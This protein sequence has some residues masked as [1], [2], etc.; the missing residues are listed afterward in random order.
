MIVEIKFFYENTQEDY[1][2][3][4]KLWH[5]NFKRFIFLQTLMTIKEQSKCISNCID[6]NKNILAIRWEHIDII[7]KNSIVR[8]IVLGKGFKYDNDK[9][10]YP[11]EIWIMACNS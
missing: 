11:K 7:N 6:D 1:E 5:E 9:T 2:N 10:W 8:N 3:Y 4:N